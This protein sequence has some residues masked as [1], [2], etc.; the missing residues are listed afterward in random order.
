MNKCLTL[1]YDGKNINNKL[2]EGKEDIEKLE[3]A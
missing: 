2:D 3:E 1:I